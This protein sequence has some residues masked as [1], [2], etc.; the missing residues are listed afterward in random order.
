[1]GGVIGRYAN[2]IAGGTVIIEGEKYK[3]STS[4][5]GYHL[6]G[7]EQ[8]FNKKVFDFAILKND[9]SSIRFFYTSHDME[10]GFPGKL[11]VRVT[12]TLDES[13]NWHIEYECNSDKTTILNLTQHAY[14][15]LKGHEGGT[16]LDHRAAIY[17]SLYLPVNKMQV[18][19]GELA[20]VK[21]TPFDFNMAAGIGTRIENT[22][23]QL[24]LSNGYDHSWVLKR[25]SSQELIHAATIK[26]MTSGRK[27]DVYTTEPAIH[28]YSGNYLDKV[29]GKNNAV[30]DKRSGFCLETQHY[31]DAPNQPG[32]P[33]TILKAGE[34]FY[35]K[36]I[37]SLS[38]I[39]D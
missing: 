8:G 39:N 6:H 17:S 7:G 14:F 2:R 9:P 20:P 3:L 28:C 25:T 4:K 18:P 13:D 31:P 12:Y 23:E 29:N 33:S 34:K 27:L 15:N 19:T 38:L 5:D 26:E 10:E 30:Y 37:F 32:F 16:I 1:M 11:E 35:S 21:G 24:I 22:N 36:T